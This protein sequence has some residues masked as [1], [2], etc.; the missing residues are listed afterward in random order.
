MKST[1]IPSR[2]SRTEIIAAITAI[3][4]AIQGKICEQVKTLAN[5]Q[6]AKYY[7]LQYWH[8]G[9]NH[10]THIPKD[11]LEEFRKAVDGGTRLR[12]LADELSELDSASILSSS[13]HLKKKSPKSPS[14]A[15]R[16]SPR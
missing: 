8:D 4:A 6:Q 12:R 9:R 3:P 11:K 5:G 1:S 13:D 10:T 15:P 16:T 7:N 2:R 14:R